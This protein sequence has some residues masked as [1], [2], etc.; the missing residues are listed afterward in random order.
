[1]E[2]RTERLTLRPWRRG[3]EEA[4]AREADDMEVWRWVRDRFPHPYTVE[5]A[6]RWI[7]FT[8]AQP[9]PPRNFG[10]VHGEA[11]IGGV[12]IEVMQD[13]QRCTAEVGY[14]LGRAWWG[15]GFAT[16]AVRRIVPY[17]FETFAALTRLEAHV[18]VSNAASARVLEKA[19]FECEARLRRA[20]IKQGVVQDD[21]IFALLRG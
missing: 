16:E 12:G 21:L 7:D 3:D 4:L 9:G 10:I 6:G 14:W 15:R 19:G 18:F 5:D 1:M 13:V 8:M 17:A 11:P 2:L 20:V